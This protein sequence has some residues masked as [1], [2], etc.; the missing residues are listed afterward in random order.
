[1]RNQFRAALIVEAIVLGVALG[2]SIVYFCMRL[3]RYGGILDVLLVLVWIVFAAMLLLVY[4]SRMIE[5]E[6]LMRQFFLSHDWA[7]N[8]EIGYVPLS[9]IVPDCDPYEFV[10]FA[11]ESLARM[12]YGFEVADAPEDFSPEYLIS[13]SRFEFHFAGEESD[14]DDACVVVDKWTGTLQRVELKPDGT[15]AYEEI[16]AYSNAKELAT[17]LNANDAIE[18]AG[19][20]LDSASG[21]ADSWRE[22]SDSLLG[23]IGGVSGGASS[24]EGYNAE[25]DL[26]SLLGPA[27]KS[28]AGG[29]SN[30]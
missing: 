16:G 15:H 18:C 17:L 10:T 19:D 9:R 25:S 28:V 6:K 30:L 5:R 29:A 8:P 26:F 24:P 21:G 7:Y 4:R 23:L 11:A 3:Y 12:S 1:M 27:G 20:L 2:F 13:S 14:Q 22:R